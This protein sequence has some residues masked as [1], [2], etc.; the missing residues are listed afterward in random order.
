MET[1]YNI[2][3]A[4]SLQKEAYEAPFIEIFEAKVELGYYSSLDTPTD[5]GSY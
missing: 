1:K 4:A 2:V 5:D 3:D